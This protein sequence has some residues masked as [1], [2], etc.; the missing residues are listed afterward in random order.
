VLPGPAAGR[1]RAALRELG[2]P[3]FEAPDDAMLRVLGHLIEYQGNKAE[4]TEP[5]RRPASLPPPASLLPGPVGPAELSRLLSLYG[6]ALP[7]EAVARDV[8]AAVTAA[9]GI[10]FPVAL[11][12]IARDLVHKSDAGAV[13]LDLRDDA[14]V[15]AA[16]QAIAAAVAS[17][18]SS[19]IE[20]CLVQEMVRGG[21]ELIV[22]I[23]RD[24]QYGPIVLVGSGGLLVELLRDVEI[25]S[26]PVSHAQAVDLLHWLRSAPILA[27]IR[28]QPPLDLDAAADAIERMSWLAVDLGARLA[29][30][31]INPLVV[32]TRGAV[33]VDVRATIDGGG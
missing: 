19:A 32:R 1:P 30:A 16:W 15:R 17:K 21:A 26:A 2:V 33:A 25:A 8:D 3:V 7:R 28:G 5:S 13:Q 27:G 20:G 18:H 6:I 12:G 14:A 24:P 4:S 29:D 11:K 10:G 23:R 31:E 22:G 9:R